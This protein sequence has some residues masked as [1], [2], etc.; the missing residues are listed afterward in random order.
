MSDGIEN[1]RRFVAACTDA[2]PPRSPVLALYRRLVRGNVTGVVHG[3]L[4]RTAAALGVRLEEAVDE[5]LRLQGPRTPHLR[6]VPGELVACVGA[7]WPLST[8]E[9]ARLELTEFHIS[10]AERCS[11]PVAGPL[12]MD[13][14][15][16]F[17][18]PLALEAFGHAVQDDPTVVDPHAL[19]FYRDASEHVR[20]L[21]LTPM[22]QVL[23][24]EA[25][26]GETMQHALI[27]ATTECG[28]A[29][30]ETTLTSTARF[31]DDLSER[32]VLLGA[33]G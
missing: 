29:L 16:A 30:D 25:L 31:L 23:V 10:Y 28:L 14:A 22:A 18:G 32:G 12:A 27:T 20:T 2:E 19:L 21:R 13:A 24:R 26:A 1:E 33:A 9:L 3:V 15:L 5:F 4:P 8:R 6:D 11:P 7:R 17:A